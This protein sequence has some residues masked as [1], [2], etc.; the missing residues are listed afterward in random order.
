MTPEPFAPKHVYQ[1]L[2]RKTPDGPWD[3]IC[4]IKA[5]TH[6]EAFRKAMLAIETSH[7]DKPIRLEQVSPDEHTG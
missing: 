4:S 3:F 2:V 6:P 5:D 1:L 7:Y